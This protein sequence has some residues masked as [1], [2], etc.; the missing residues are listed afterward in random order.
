MLVSLRRAPGGEPSAGGGVTCRVPVRGDGG[1]QV[2]AGG[3]HCLPFSRL[4][5]LDAEAHKTLKELEE[6]KAAGADGAHRQ[7]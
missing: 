4:A 1:L 3:S 2:R 5:W 6:V 7:R